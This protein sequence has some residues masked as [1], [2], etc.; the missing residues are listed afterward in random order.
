MEDPMPATLTDVA[1]SAGVA[2]STASRAYSDPDRVG[3]E[4]LR[5]IRRVAQELG[6]EPPVARLVDA[7]VPATSTVAV[8]VPDISNPVFAAFVKAA[9][10]Q[11]W[12]RRQTVVLADT[13]LNPDRERETIVHLRD[14]VDG[15]VLCSPRLDAEQI[16]TLCPRI[17]VVLVNREA[18]GTDCVVA[19]ASDGLRQTID[20]LGALGHRR[21]AY[22]QG[23]QQSWS[24]EH[25]V[26]LVRT[27][28]ADAGLELHVLGWQAETVA[29]GTAAAA[30]VVATGASAVITH[31]DLMALGVIAGVRALGLRVP[32]DLSVVGIDD[33]PLAAITHPTL[34]SVAVP[35]AR[36]GALSLELLER[37]LGGD[38][39]TPRAV[40]LPTQLVVRGSTGPAAARA[41]TDAVAPEQELA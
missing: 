25:R 16:L 24:N 4:T 18:A 41:A 11:G 29:G 20:Y 10:S 14:R 38:R 12:Y 9:Q 32:D 19:D 34:T 3:P 23:S 15:M 40:R 30:G 35:M 33:I 26:G 31:N 39:Q 6:Y 27:L 17:P 36:A 21:L 7:P 28:A 37:N 8:I 22:V 1:K 2:L 5:K 13:D